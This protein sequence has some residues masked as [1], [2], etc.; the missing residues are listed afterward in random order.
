MDM[1]IPRD[2]ISAS[3]DGEC[4][5]DERAVVRQ[6]LEQ[7]EAARLE[8]RDCVQ[9]SQ[10][11]SQL[12][13]QSAPA[14][15]DA[16]VRQAVEREMLLGQSAPAVPPPRRIRSLP[17][18]AYL[19]VGLAAGILVVVGWYGLVDPRWHPLQPRGAGETLAQLDD[20]ARRLVQQPLDRLSDAQP[21]A[22]EQAIE[23][24]SAPGLYAGGVAGASADGDD[25]SSARK[26][27]SPLPAGI[28]ENADVANAPP[29]PQKSALPGGLLETDGIEGTG[30]YGRT[31]GSADPAAD[32]SSQSG[33]PRFRF[34]RQLN[35]AQVGEVVEALKVSA[36]D[37]SVV[38]L[39]VVDRWESLAQLRVV[40]S[41]NQLE[42]DEEQQ[43]DRQQLDRQ[44][45]DQQQLL[46]GVFIEASD[47]ELASALSEIQKLDNLQEL[48]VAQSVSLADVS[49]NLIA[50]HPETSSLNKRARSL[51][52]AKGN[53]AAPKQASPASPSPTRDTVA[54]KNAKSKNRS[55]QAG[56]QLKGAVAKTQ[57]KL[58]AA[59]LALPTRHPVMFKPSL[60]ARQKGSSHS[61]RRERADRGADSRR[62]E[63]KSGEQ[64]KVVVLFVLV[65][66]NTQKGIDGQRRNKKRQQNPV[67]CSTDD[68]A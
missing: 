17:R 64:N 34:L 53:E 52:K 20:D 33:Q 1:G 31:Y 67:E 55:R 66:E 8:K 62:S 38:K 45:V 36:N 15:F 46:V 7:S 28:G 18:L 57:A 48:S 43:L 11:L 24:V 12:P 22:E 42:S 23:G 49:R 4:T 37:V 14:G 61:L 58:G 60:L 5:P 47:Q 51:K 35:A 13:D 10:L 2:L 21:V 32:K 50:S 29:K 9:I 6:V 63:L 25:S 16:Q 27:V 39:T 26:I 40:L 19:F 3:H 65:A 59:K 30:G 44:Q 54:G 56:A 41:E 68:S